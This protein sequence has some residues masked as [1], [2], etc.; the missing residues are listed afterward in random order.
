MHKLIFIIISAVLFSAFSFDNYSHYN[1]KEFGAK[2]DGKVLDTKSIQDAIDQAFDDGGGTIEISPGTYKI[3]TL[4]LRDNINLHLQSGAVLL[5][6]SDIKDYTELISRFESR[7]NKLYAKYFMIFAEGASNISITGRGEINGNGVDNFKVIRPQSQR[8]NMIRLVDCHNVYVTG[9]SLLE[10]ANW[11]LHLLGCSD[12]SVD[13][14]AIKNSGVGNRDGIDIDACQSVTISNSTFSTTDDSIV[15]KSTCDNLCQDITITNCIVLFT[16]GSAI[17]TGTESNGGF[18]NITISNCVLKNI[19][20][21]TGIDLIA[22][23]GG[24]LQNI[25]INN[26][27]MDNVA[28]PIFIRLGLRAR[29]Y[30]PTQYVKEIKDIRDIYLSN[31]HVTNAKFPSSIMGLH[32]HKIKNI[33]LTNYSVRYVDTQEH[34]PYDKVPLKEFSYPMAIMFKNLPAYGFY[35]R[36]VEGL[37]FENITMYSAENEDRPAIT[38]DRVSDSELLSIK[39]TVKNQ[40]VPMLHFRNLNKLL[41]S[42][43]RSIGF[44]DVL[45]EIEDSSC[46]NLRFF[47][48]YLL[49]NQN[50]TSKVKAISSE[51]PFYDFPA[52]IKYSVEGGQVIHGLMA[53]NCN[54]GAL[55]VAFNVPGKE[56]LQLC[57]LMLNDGSRPEKIVIKYEEVCQEFTV[58]WDEWGWAPITLL[59]EF[60]E[61]K[62]I[63]FEISSKDPN[64]CLKIAKVYILNPNFKFTD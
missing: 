54:R 51:I 50:E 46:S 43:C 33:Y 15:L 36:N 8:P 40:F 7:T 18:K 12:V 49:A 32:N 56:K 11:T 60:D 28:T 1:V 4:I 31:I 55:R 45:V 29:P 19:T 22:V 35:C 26:I 6:S 58:N 59:K 42:S 5:G 61:E 16:G 2:G 64:S 9:L 25:S 39:A 57:L 47:N 37:H 44:N 24:I 30:K 63:N 10:S 27:I 14:I 38:L 21:H 13:N 48:N 53:H 41:T 23:D 62:E 34:I 3:G 17:K 52:N 20:K